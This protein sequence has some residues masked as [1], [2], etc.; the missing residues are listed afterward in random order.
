MTLSST[1]SAHMMNEPTECNTST[2][3]HEMADFSV[4]AQW[5][6]SEYFFKN[7]NY[8][9]KHMLKFL[10]HKTRCNIMVQYKFILSQCPKQQHHPH[11]WN[12]LS[13]GANG[14]TMSVQTQRTWMTA[15]QEK[16]KKKT[17]ISSTNASAKMCAHNAYASINKPGGH[18]G[19]KLP[20]VRIQN[21]LFEVKFGEWQ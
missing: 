17:N 3:N 20:Q 10:N 7:C 9:L 16:K 6:S 11:V 5:H 8:N 19:P 1:D 18:N 2:A 15:E 4:V 13:L 21:F 12:K 14:T